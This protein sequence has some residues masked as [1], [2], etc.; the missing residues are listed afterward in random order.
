M[1]LIEEGSIVKLSDNREYVAFSVVNV[2]GRSLVYFMSATQP[3]EMVF[4]EQ[5]IVDDNLNIRILKDQAEKEAALKLF[6][7]LNIKE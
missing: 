7:K 5:S 3:I 4:A 6:V 2:E 1:K